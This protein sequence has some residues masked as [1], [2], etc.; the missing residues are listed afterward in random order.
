MLHCLAPR[1]SLTRT[2]RRSPLPLNVVGDQVNH[3]DATTAK[4]APADVRALR[5]G[6]AFTVKFDVTLHF[7]ISVLRRVRHPRG[8]AAVIVAIHAYTASLSI[9]FTPRT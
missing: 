9:H 4:L 5:A 1:L 2:P 6:R 7:T 3:D 8:P